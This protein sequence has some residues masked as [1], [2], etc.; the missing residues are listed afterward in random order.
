MHQIAARLNS[1][2]AAK[3]DFNQIW[4]QLRVK[5]SIAVYFVLNSE[6]SFSKVSMAL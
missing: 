4:S 5:V 3:V 1:P 2:N 6:Q